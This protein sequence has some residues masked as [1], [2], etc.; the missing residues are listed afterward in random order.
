MAQITEKQAIA[1]KNIEAILNI[2][3]TGGTKRDAWLWMQEY[4]PK[5]VETETQRVLSQRTR[6]T[7]TPRFPDSLDNLLSEE[8]VDE[9]EYKYDFDADLDNEIKATKKYLGFH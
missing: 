1:I 7:T 4:M 6:I 5:S 3:F 9:Y 2:K 8:K